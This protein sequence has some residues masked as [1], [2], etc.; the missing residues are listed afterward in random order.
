MDRSSHGPFTPALFTSWKDF[1][2]G[3][4][5]FRVDGRKVTTEEIER[6]PH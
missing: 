1:D 6:P 3:P 2:D 5:K 4:F